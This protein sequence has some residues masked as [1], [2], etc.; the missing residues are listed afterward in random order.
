MHLYHLPH[1]ETAG[2]VLLSHFWKSHSECILLTERW[3]F[4]RPEGWILYLRN[5]YS[6]VGSSAF[7]QC[8]TLC[9][10]HDMEKI[11]LGM[12]EVAQSLCPFYSCVSAE[13]N[14]CKMWLP[15]LVDY[16]NRL[17]PQNLPHL[18]HQPSSD[19]TN[20]CLLPIYSPG[21]LKSHLSCR[22]D[23]TFYNCQGGIALLHMWAK[24]FKTWV[25]KVRL[26]NLYVDT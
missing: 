26:L 1:W 22:K 25:P 12:E 20:L 13:T 2:F 19:G 11:S 14:W 17:R 9:C 16:G 6:I 23:V 15:A 3:W 4:A 21:A 10:P 8:P 5:R 24:I 7:P 18:N